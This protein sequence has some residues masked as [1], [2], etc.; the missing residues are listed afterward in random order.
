MNAY[1]MR[2][3]AFDTVHH[4]LF[5][6]T[7]QDGVW[8]YDLSNSPPTW[9]DTGGGVSTSYVNCL[10]YDT[11]GR[12]LYAGTDSDGVWCYD[13]VSDTW[14]DIGGGVAT[15]ETICLT[16]GGGRLYAGCYDHLTTYK[17]V[18]CYDPASPGPDK[19][20]DTGLAA[21][22]VHDLVY[23]EARGLLYAG[24]GE[25]Y[26][27]SG[28]QGV[29]CDDPA[30]PGWSDISAGDI[31]TYKTNSLAL[32]GDTLYAGICDGSG[33]PSVYKGV[34]QYDLTN[35]SGGWTNTGGS[36][37]GFEA[38]ALTWDGA[39]LYA[40]RVD[41]TQPVYDS[42][43]GVWWYDPTIP[44][45]DKWTDTGGLLANSIVYDL[46]WDRENDRLYASCWYSFLGTWDGVWWYDPG[47]GEWGD[48]QGDIASYYVSSLV[49]DE[50]LHRLYAGTGGEGAW[51]SGAPPAILAPGPDLGR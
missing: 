29:W 12:L 50:E 7:S 46:A 36:M 30:G 18:W 8:L 21:P 40:S 20:T 34:W 4:H 23:D 9:S 5:A 47:A 13:P 19:W 31:G 37:D 48:T 24:T 43:D 28:G 49:Y 32:G 33:I 44:A 15:Y 2:S 16:F 17:G 14:T 45:P 51:Y 25:K 39:R 6:G 26:T 3:L 11:A 1:E 41:P 42:G 38:Y 10:A 35:P 22:A 27:D